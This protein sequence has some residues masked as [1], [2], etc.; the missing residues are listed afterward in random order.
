MGCSPPGFSVHGDSP[1]KDT[2]VGSQALLQGIFP[3]QVSNPGLPLCRWILYH[4]SYEGRS[5]VGFYFN[6]SMSMIIFPLLIKFLKKI[7]FMGERC[8]VT[9]VCSSVWGHLG[10]R[11]LCTVFIQ[12]FRNT[13][14]KMPATSS[15]NSVTHSKLLNVFNPQFSLSH[16]KLKY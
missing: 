9:S 2:G 3:T 14:I 8:T 13:W 6:F 4:L 15:Y 5:L 1:G 10:S 16:C 12:R 7:I 11:S